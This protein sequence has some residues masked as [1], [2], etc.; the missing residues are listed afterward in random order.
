MNRGRAGRWWCG[1]VQSW[2]P[3]CLF[4][5]NKSTRL[6]LVLSPVQIESTGM[7]RRGWRWHWHELLHVPDLKATLAASSF[8]CK[9]SGPALVCGGLWP[10]RDH[11]PSVGPGGAQQ[12]AQGPTYL[13]PMGAS[14]GGAATKT[15]IH[16]QRQRVG[17]GGGP[18]L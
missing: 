16:V 9:T 4:N 10:R 7:G 5:V 14:V 3:A 17:W 6:P 18:Y 2:P 13:A 11:L 12:A 15:P 8:H 1:G